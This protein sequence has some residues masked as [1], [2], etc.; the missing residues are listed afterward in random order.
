MTLK[1][2][3][4]RLER[5]SPRFFGDVA[6]MPTPVLESL[7]R[8]AFQDGNHTEEEGGLY[9]RLKDRGFEFS[10]ARSRL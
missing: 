10:V 9:R 6:E 1:R 3:I 2:R 5:A 4:D 7:V 8:K